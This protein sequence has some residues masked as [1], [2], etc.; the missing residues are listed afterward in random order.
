MNKREKLK[1]DLKQLDRI[2]EKI[3]GIELLLK[4]T[5]R[6]K[7]FTVSDSYYGLPPIMID[8]HNSTDAMETILANQLSHLKCEK[9]VLEIDLGVGE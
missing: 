4:D 3:E 8:Y 6:T 9:N 2:D 5:D 7:F 1:A